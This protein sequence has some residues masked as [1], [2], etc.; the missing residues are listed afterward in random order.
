VNFFYLPIRTAQIYFSTILVVTENVCDQKD[1]TNTNPKN[2]LQEF[3]SPNINSDALL[4]LIA[5][6]SDYDKKV[7]N[8][9]PACLYY[10][11]TSRKLNLPNSK[12]SALGKCEYTMFS[13]QIINIYFKY[14]KDGHGEDIYAMN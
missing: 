11:L 12:G 3:C 9:E 7:G 4:D 8:N 1:T 14:D 10:G 5:R 6:F 2:P 13:I